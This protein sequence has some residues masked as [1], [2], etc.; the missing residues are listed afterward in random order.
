MIDL[1]INPV[2]RKKNIQRCRENGILLPTYAQMRD[3]ALIPDAIKQ[4]LAH[5]G[6]WDVHVRNLFRINWHNEPTDKGG[7]F[8][9]VNFIELPSAITGTKARIV[10]IGREVTG[11]RK[12]CEPPPPRSARSPSPSR[13]G[14]FVAAIIPPTRFS[15]SMPHSCL[16]PDRARGRYSWRVPA[17]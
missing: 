9:G 4:E 7:K 11:R 15:P 14:L 17:R 3:P 8:G 16:S 12:D 6:L 10:G 5:I 13:G 1:N 2:Q